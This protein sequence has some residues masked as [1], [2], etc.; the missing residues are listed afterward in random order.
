MANG[1][2][3]TRLPAPQWQHVRAGGSRRCEAEG[4]RRAAREGASHGGS[5]AG[6]A[7]SVSNMRRGDQAVRLTAAIGDAVRR[8]KS[9][10]GVCLGGA[11]VWG[12]KPGGWGARIRLGANFKGARHTWSSIV[13]DKAT[14][15]LSHLSGPRQRRL[16]PCGESVCVNSR[17]TPSVGP[18]SF[19]T[20][21]FVCNRVFPA[22]LLV[23][24]L[25]TSLH[26][27]DSHDSYR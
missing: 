10:A 5:G 23:S 20:V 1:Q 15:E 21:C 14:Q 8:G 12:S 22:L 27:P 17:E 25:S 2:Q 18:K 13:I 26:P 7:G 19:P 16:V 9:A 11:V 3:R 4:R 24:A 6:G